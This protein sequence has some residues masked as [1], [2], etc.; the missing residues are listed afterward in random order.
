MTQ[1]IGGP[2]DLTSIELPET[3][4]TIGGNAFGGCENLSSINL[5]AS[6]TQIEKQAFLNCRSLASFTC[7]A[8]N[9]PTCGSYVFELMPKNTLYV[10]E[11]AITLYQ[12]TS[13]WN[14]FKNIEAINS[15]A[16]I[17]SLLANPENEISVYSTHGILIKKDCKVKDLK[18]LAK[19][20]YIIVS[21]KEHYKISI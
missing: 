17:E 12:S 13:P 15:D 11:E 10:P 16:G 3:I 18:S 4:T 19:G 20:I 6:V 1:V 7:K 2:L 9:P 8:L 14:Q 21:G 5:P